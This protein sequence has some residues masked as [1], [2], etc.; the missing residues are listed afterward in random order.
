LGA[1]PGE[2]AAGALTWVRSQ[3]G[4]TIWAFRCERFVEEAFGTRYQFESAWDAAKNLRLHRGSI[5]SAPVG[6]LVYFRPDAVNDG[7]GHV[8]LSLGGGKMISALDT[9]QI[10]DVSESPFW[11]SLYR[12]W[13]NAPLTWPGR[14]PLPPGP[15]GPLTDS[16]VQV[17][18]PAFGSIV[19]GLVQLAASA[20]NVGGVAFL[21]YYATDPTNSKTIGWHA[22]GDAIGANGTWTLAWNTQGVPDQANPSWGTVNVAAVALDANGTQTG[23]RDYRR[24]AINNSPISQQPPPVMPPPSATTYSEQEG[25]HGVNTFTDYD[26]ASGPGPFISPLSTVQ[27][28][29][30][31]YDP[32]IA[33]VNP[34]GYWYRIASSPWSN[35][36][37]APANTFFNGDP[38][39]GPYTHNTDFAVPDC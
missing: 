19:G 30:K 11:R 4:Q 32:T 33:S 36:Y 13:A 12:G 2:R 31:V 7:Y 9:V 27:V 28:S 14:I 26:N 34:D 35:E 10:T 37:Y 8:G 1:G 22:L 21:A 20:A 38:I 24:I 29:C 18:A 6:S 15:T 16:S 17:T 39:D 25:H 23:T 3:L 5:R